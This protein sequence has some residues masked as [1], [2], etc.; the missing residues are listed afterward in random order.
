MQEYRAP[1]AASPDHRRHDA[2]AQSSF[3]VPVESVSSDAVSPV[4]STDNAA[5]PKAAAPAPRPTRGRPPRRHTVPAPDNGAREANSN[6]TD[7]PLPDSILP[8]I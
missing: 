1:R 6:T 3:D 5:E 8:Q 2:S 4:N 7:I